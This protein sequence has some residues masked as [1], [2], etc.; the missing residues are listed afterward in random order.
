MPIDVTLWVYDARA[1]PRLCECPG[2]RRAREA[3]GPGYR[4]RDGERLD[5]TALAL[6]ECPYDAGHLAPEDAAFL[7][8]EGTGRPLDIGDIRLPDGGRAFING[9]MRRSFLA[10]LARVARETGARVELHYE[11]ERGDYPYESALWSFLPWEELWWS[12]SDGGAPPFHSG[13]AT[14]RPARI[15][16]EE[17]RFDLLA[18]LLAG[19]RIER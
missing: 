1:W 13:S 8:R 19:V 7:R 4:P 10:W 3:A 12:A 6:A 18:T 5:V 2:I 16:A 11:H 9:R 17:A 15:P 14:R